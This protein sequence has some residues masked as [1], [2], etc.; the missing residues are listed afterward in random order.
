MGLYYWKVRHL[1]SWETT[2]KYSAAKASSILF[3]TE[4]QMTR[5]YKV[6]VPCTAT[7]R[8]AA[9]G[10]ASISKVFLA[11]S[12]KH[13]WKVVGHFGSALN[14]LS[15]NWTKCG[16]RCKQHWWRLDGTFKLTPLLPPWTALFAQ[17]ILGHK[18][19]ETQQYGSHRT[20]STN[21]KGR[22]PMIVSPYFLSQNSTDF[23]FLVWPWFVQIFNIRIKG[24]TYYVKFFFALESRNG[25]KIVDL[26]AEIDIK[27]LGQTL[28]KWS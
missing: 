6:T 11:H 12:W 20:A 27:V 8:R 19:S 25:T 26:R 7:P 21:L 4:L 28:P 23:L 2:A 13:L 10:A 15:P 5:V 17:T 1:S 3:V 9:A 16:E 14:T 18:Q 22:S 24:L